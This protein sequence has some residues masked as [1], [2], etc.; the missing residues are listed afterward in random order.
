LAPIGL[1]AGFFSATTGVSAGFA[2]VAALTSGDI[3]L[4]VVFLAD[5]VATAFL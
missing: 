1:G 5:F 4:T 2:G 3:G